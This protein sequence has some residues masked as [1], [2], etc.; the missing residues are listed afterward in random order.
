MKIT[1]SQDKVNTMLFIKNHCFLSGGSQNIKFWDI[2][3]PICQAYKYENGATSD[4]T[5]LFTIDID[6]KNEKFMF[7]SGSKNGEVFLWE[8][9]AEFYHGAHRSSIVDLSYSKEC[10]LFLSV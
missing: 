10:D 5:H 1:H 3:N 6:S 7:A 8:E 4:I 9:C 2:R